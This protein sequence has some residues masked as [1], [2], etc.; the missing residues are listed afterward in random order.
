MKVR[1]GFVSNSSS[2]SHIVIL[3][4][5]FK[6]SDEQVKE[7]CERYNNWGDEVLTPEQAEV[8]ANEIIDRICSQKET[9]TC[10]EGY[11]EENPPAGTQIFLE[12]FEELIEIA[13]MDTGPESGLCIN[14][15][16]DE[17]RDKNIDK[18]HKIIQKQ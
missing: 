17:C 15:F 9:W 14:I 3:S 5:N 13:S 7:F 10:Y 6:L 4:R 11:G 8:R 16:A 12:V 1:N 2:T 18:L